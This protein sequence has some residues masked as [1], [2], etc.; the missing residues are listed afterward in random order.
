MTAF[1]AE[2]GVEELCLEYFADLGWQVLNGP[3]IAPGEVSE[4]R[5]SYGD[6]LLEGRI[7][8]AIE[9]LNPGLG[10]EEVG[11]VI[12]TLRR[13]E[14]ADVLTENWR[15]YQLWDIHVG[16]GGTPST[17]DVGGIPTSSSHIMWSLRVDGYP[18]TS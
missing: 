16:G 5:S 14:S 13:P 2:S 9:R 4:E 12:A 3:S 8:A 15:I 1:L 17:P 18:S 7:R 6:V 11:E 10:P